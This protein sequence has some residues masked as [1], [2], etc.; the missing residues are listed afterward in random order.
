V[1]CNVKF[2]PAYLDYLGNS[3]IMYEPYLVFHITC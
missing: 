1:E 2:S 3:R